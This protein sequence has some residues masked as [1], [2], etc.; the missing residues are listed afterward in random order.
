V[1]QINLGDLQ[2]HGRL[3]GGFVLGV[4]E[5]D[6]FALI[7]GAQTGL[8]AGRRFLG[9]EN[10]RPPEQNES[11]LHEFDSLN[12]E[13]SPVSSAFTNASFGEFQRIVANCSSAHQFTDTFTDSGQS[14]A[15][16]LLPH[17]RLRMEPVAGFEPAISSPP[18]FYTHEQGTVS[19]LLSAH[20]RE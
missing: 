5:S 3:P 18:V 9:V 19:C 6:G 10:A 8:S 11:R 13:A 1:L 7:F 16:K 4:K 15:F 12:R 17:T 14:G 20:S 2:V